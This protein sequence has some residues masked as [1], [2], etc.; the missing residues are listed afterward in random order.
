MQAGKLRHRVQLQKKDQ[1]QDPYSGE[2]LDDW[3][4]TATVW[5]SV[6]PL[7]VR[8]FIAAGAERAAVTTRIVI[9]YRAGVTAQMR[10]VHRDRIYNIQGVQPDP[11]SGREYL[12]LPCVEG[13]N[14]G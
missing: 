6:E 8:E 2:M 12:T 5:A 1:R 7:S 9:R 3:Q 4:T 14:D 11:R 10:I 13:V